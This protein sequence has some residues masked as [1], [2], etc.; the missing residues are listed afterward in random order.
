LWW[1]SRCCNKTSGCAVKRW[2]CIVVSQ[3]VFLLRLC[4]GAVKRWRCIVVSQ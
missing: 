3:L 2:R 4:G 1:T